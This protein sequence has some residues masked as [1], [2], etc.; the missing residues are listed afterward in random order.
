MGLAIASSLVLLGASGVAISRLSP[1]DSGPA[2]SE[3]AIPDPETGSGPQAGSTAG[4]DEAAPAS[5]GSGVAPSTPSASPGT[6]RLRTGRSIKAVTRSATSSDGGMA[7]KTGGPAATPGG[8]GE[9]TAGSNGPAGGSPDGSAGGNVSPDPQGPPESSS[10]AAASASVG[11]GESGAVAA[12]ILGMH[13]EVDLTIGSNPLI[14]NAPPSNGTGIGLGGRLL[15]PP[16]TTP[17]LPG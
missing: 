17:I 11:E 8:S 7:N 12:V 2:P 5:D 14:G 15:Q 13:T 9:T 16:P 1:D 10:L 3:V 4:G 6:G